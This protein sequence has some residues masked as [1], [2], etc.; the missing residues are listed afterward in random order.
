MFWIILALILWGGI[1]SLLASL[2]AKTIAKGWLGER[3]VR[4]YR[5]AYNLLAGVS[6]LPIL[7]LAAV[8]PDRRLYLAPLPWS[9]LMVLIEFLAVVMLLVAFRQTDIWEFL[10]LRQL[11]SPDKPAQTGDSLVTSQGHLV[12]AGL[13][14]HIRH[15]LYSAGLLFIW[16]TPLMT[17]NLLVIN[18][19]LTIYIVIGAY[20]EERKLHETFG[21][22]YSDYAAVTPMFIPFIKGNKTRR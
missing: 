16:F 6:F 21:Q 19:G 15:P 11:M 22:E 13:Y 5:L 3:L 14:R 2:K 20:L 12:M 10:G 8:L 9:G 17:V 18:I 4:F 1:H 7:A